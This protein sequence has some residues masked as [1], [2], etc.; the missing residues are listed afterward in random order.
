MAIVQTVTETIFL[1][2]V[3]AA[4]RV[5]NFGYNGWRKIFEYLEQYSEDTG[6][7]VEL[8]VVAI[9]CDY[10]SF[11]SVEAYVNECGIP[12]NASRYT[13]ESLDEGEKLEAIREFLEGK[14]SIICC[15]DESIIYASF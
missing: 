15:D 1:D 10:S 3:R 7:N 5:E 8:D 9:C 11:D 14:T 12:G 13:W 2:A 4:G 6:E